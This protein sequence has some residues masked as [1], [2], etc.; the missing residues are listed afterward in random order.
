MDGHELHLTVREALVSHCGRFPGYVLLPGESVFA[1]DVH[2]VVVPSQEEYALVP[3]YL[4]E[5]P[6]YAPADVR[7]VGTEQGQYPAVPGPHAHQSLPV[8]AGV[9]ADELAALLQ[10]LPR[11]AVCVLD[12]A[13]L[14]GAPVLLEIEDVGHVASVE[15]VYALP[16][17]PHAE[18]AVVVG[19]P[20]GPEEVV[21]GA[22]E[23]LVFI[24]YDVFVGRNV[25]SP[26]DDVGGHVE[27]VLEVD[28]A[29]LCQVLLIC[30]VYGSDHFLEACQLF[31]DAVFP[32]PGVDL[33]PGPVVSFYEEYGGGDH[34]A[35]GGD[36]GQHVGDSLLEYLLGVRMP[37]FHP[38]LLQ[39]LFQPGEKVVFGTVVR[40]ELYEV[41]AVLAVYAPLPLDSFKVVLLG[42]GV[43]I[44]HERSDVAVAVGTEVLYV[45]VCAL[46]VE[47]GAVLPEFG[48]SGIDRIR[49]LVGVLDAVP[50]QEVGDLPLPVALHPLAVEGE[51]GVLTEVVDVFRPVGEAVLVLGHVEI[52]GEEVV[53]RFEVS[54][55]RLS[56][57][58]FALDEF[59][60]VY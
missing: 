59:I 56:V 53:Q 9:P 34:G 27:H 23:V 5:Y 3:G 28:L 32:G 8:L 60:D 22:G 48:A 39:L 6:G 51:E 44:H 18:Q 54:Y 21:P 30:I 11:E 4:R 37:E 24:H 45:D 15:P 57:V 25:T 52:E 13:D 7:V 46:E 42:I 35:Q 1:E 10:E 29:V 26:A 58:E 50:R 36:L 49:V 14:R 31:R 41:G 12:P 2:V 16:V 47:I 55:V 20:H 33:V 17:V 38:P 40:V 19:I 43:V